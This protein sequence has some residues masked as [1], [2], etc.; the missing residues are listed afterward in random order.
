MASDAPRCKTCAF[1]ESLDS[2]DQAF[3]DLKVRTDPKGVSRGHDRP[4]GMSSFSVMVS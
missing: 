4:A 3:F 2:A 1:C